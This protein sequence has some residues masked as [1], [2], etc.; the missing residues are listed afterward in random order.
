MIRRLPTASGGSAYYQRGVLHR[1]D[2]GSHTGTRGGS[3]AS[4]AGLSGD[5]LAG[6]TETASGMKNGSVTSR[7]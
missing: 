2:S 5:G 3:G 1:Q 7:T 6:A 4:R